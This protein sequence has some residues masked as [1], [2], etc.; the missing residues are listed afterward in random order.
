VPSAP[1]PGLERLGTDYGGWVVPC[2]LI[3]A[4]WVCYSAGAGADVSFDIELLNLGAFVRAFD[5]FRPFREKA[6]RETGGNPRYSFDE[7][8][9]AAADGPVIMFGRQDSG[10]GSVS[11]VNL[12]GVETAHEIQGRSVPSLMAEHGDGE[13]RLLKMDIEGSEYDVLRSLDLAALGVQVLCVELHEHRPAHEAKALLAH[14]GDQG[15]EVVHNGGGTDFTL[16]SRELAA[17]ARN[18]SAG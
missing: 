9:I 17:T 3:G 5:P 4:G 10:G 18:A 6:E 2:A 8:A 1:V 13:V 14:L 11:A 12:Y 7:V 16:M 15:Y